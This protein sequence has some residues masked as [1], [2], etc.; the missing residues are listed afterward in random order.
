[1]PAIQAE[2]LGTA[3]EEVER[4]MNPN[5]GAPN[6][7]FGIKTC[8]FCGGTASIRVNTGTLNCKAE[9]NKC[10]VVMKRSFKGNSKIEYLLIGLM[11]EEWNRRDGE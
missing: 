4:G 5:E 9:C 6:S 3:E 10:G 2:H 11:R 7:K 8:P 1:M